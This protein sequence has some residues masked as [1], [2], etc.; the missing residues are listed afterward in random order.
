MS[1]VRIRL[2]TLE[3]TRKSMRTRQ[4][5]GKEKA[6]A[7]V[8]EDIAAKVARVGARPEDE[9]PGVLHPKADASYAEEIIGL[10]DAPRTRSN[11]MATRVAPQGEHG[12]HIG[13]TA[14]LRPGVHL[15]I[16]RE[17]CEG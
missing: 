11:I 13:G 7:K 15:Q 1:P 4:E 3:R 17:G 6:R 8:E 12:R 14:V 2:N 10:Q 9:H 16:Q 5:R